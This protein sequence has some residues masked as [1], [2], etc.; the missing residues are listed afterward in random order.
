[1]HKGLIVPLN[2]VAGTPTT[3]DL[4]LGNLPVGKDYALIIE[5]LSKDATPKLAATSCNYVQSLTAGTNATVL[6]R[7]GVLSPIVS[8]DP[9]I[10]P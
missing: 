4:S 5:G 2:L 8:C 1:V 10:D 6:A 9:R 7:V 3:Q